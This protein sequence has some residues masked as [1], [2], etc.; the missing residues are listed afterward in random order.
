M[1]FL[2][3][4]FTDIL[5]IFLVSL[6]IYYVLQFLLE[7]RAFQILLGVILILL[8]TFFAKLLHLNTLY[9]ILSQATTLGI[10]ALV[11]LFQPE[12][13][14][15][16]ARLGE[17][18]ISF[19]TQESKTL[20]AIDEIIEAVKNM[21]KERI[22][23]LI[24][25]ERNIKIDNYLL[26]PGTLVDALITKELLETIFYP[27]TPLHDGAVIIK[28]DRIYMAG[29]FLPLSSNPELPSSFGTR[30]RAGIGITE[31]TDA[32]SLIV[33]EERGDISL[34]YSGKC[35]KNVSPSIL[36]KLLTRLLIEGLYE[37]KV[38]ID[39]ELK[40]VKTNKINSRAS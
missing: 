25:I 30:H 13:R 16:L 35:L 15:F 6:I 4:K 8:V 32:I 21:A 22:G 36:R 2:S 5:D 37:D 7:T 34:A 14:K 10:F 26:K 24:V 23:A 11:V 29:A 31:I 12:L 1:P 28:G 27:K 38:N 3:I 40:N 19:Q 20:I 18:N 39:K 17:T 9:W 33:S